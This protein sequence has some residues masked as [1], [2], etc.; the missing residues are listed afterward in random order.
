MDTMEKLY[1]NIEKKKKLINCELKHE[2]F[3]KN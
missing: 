3:K 2:S 1:Q